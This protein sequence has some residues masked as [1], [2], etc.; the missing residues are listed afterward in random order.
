M[1]CV[2]LLPFTQR[3][4]FLFDS[5][6]K[7]GRC[8]IPGNIQGQVRWGS[9]QPDVVVDVPAHCREIGLDGL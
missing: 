2:L 1:K 3:C 8:P 5:W 6:L 9:E 4:L 7:G